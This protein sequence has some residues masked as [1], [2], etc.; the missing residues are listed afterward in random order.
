MFDI[1]IDIH[2]GSLFGKKHPPL[3]GLDISLS[4][5]RL[6]ELSKPNK[7]TF[8][9]ERY[10]S[11]PL[12]H[13]VVV[14]GNIKNIEQL[15]ETVHR[16]LKKSGS[17]AKRVA[18]GL[19]AA[20]VITK[21]I[22]LPAGLPE[23]ELAVQ[24]ELELEAGQYLPFSL[25]DASLDFH[26]IGAV[27]N[28]SDASDE[29]EML[30]VAARKEKVDDR[31]AVAEAAGLKPVVMDVESYA[32]RAAL[33]RLI[34]QLPQVGQGHVV[35]VFQI[36]THTT[37]VSI[38]LNQQIVEEYDYVHEYEHEHEDEQAFN[39]NQPSVENATMQV[40]RALQFLFT[41]TPYNHVDQ[42]LLAGECAVLPGLAECVADHTQISS[43][44][45]NPFQGM[46]LAKRLRAKQLCKE[47]PAY[48]VACG[49]ALRRFDR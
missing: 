18:L 43:V 16:L 14:D 28:A 25:D 32:A 3:L 45:V 24:L 7:T 33:E 31:A 20:S 13:G 49:L 5:V 30:L 11:E 8:Q 19:P 44:V 36:D 48:L 2:I 39:D 38:L 21:T 35:A 22:V 47:A 10:A 40:V 41:S 6:V 9:L 42:I 46:K 34:P 1:G 37:H 17:Q 27:S 29:I 4:S 26:E 23:E 12:P 15:S